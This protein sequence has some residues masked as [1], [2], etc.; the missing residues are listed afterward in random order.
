ML[1]RGIIADL[2]DLW[3]DFVLLLIWLFR[4]RLRFKSLLSL[5]D[6]GNE[7]FFRNRVGLLAYD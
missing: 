4:W 6:K 3:D 1:A 5:L 2:T 7:L